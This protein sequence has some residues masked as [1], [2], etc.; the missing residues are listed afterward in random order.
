[1][2]T[3]APDNSEISTSPARAN[4]AVQ[5]E[6]HEEHARRLVRIALGEETSIATVTSITEAP[7]YQPYQQTVE[8]STGL[9][10]KP[11]PVDAEG[12]VVDMA[13]YRRIQAARAVVDEALLESSSAEDPSQQ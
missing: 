12:K 1:M 8:N 11:V 10:S 2:S 9:A 3:P 5:P 4:V 6:N 7:S 13:K